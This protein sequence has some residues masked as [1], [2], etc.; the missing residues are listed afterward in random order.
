MIRVAVTQNY[1]RAMYRLSQE[2]QISEQVL[3]GLEF[4]GEY[5]Q[6]E[7]NLQ[8]LLKHPMVDKKD[9]K[10][11]IQKI[12]EAKP[13]EKPPEEV[14][15]LLF[16]MV[17]KKRGGIIREVIDW[18]RRF[19]QQDRDIQVVEVTS[20]GELRE[21]QK[22]IIVENMKNYTGQQVVLQEKEDPSMKGGIILKIGSL[23]L[24]GSLDT[25][26]KKMEEQLVESGSK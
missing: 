23:M 9:K 18:Y 1:A 16:L 10:D 21:E 13:E 24:D 6:K 5:L 12:L 20:P 15:H 3:A 7:P 8:A 22:E 17:D 14:K 2:K 25:R 4:V 19:Y 11:V 26:L